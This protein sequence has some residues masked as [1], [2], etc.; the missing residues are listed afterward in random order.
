M[1][2]THF[3]GGTNVHRRALA[4]SFKSTE[5]LDGSSV[6]LVP[7][8]LGGL[9]FFI[10]HESCVSS[11]ATVQKNRGYFIGKAVARKYAMALP[12]GPDSQRKFMLELGLEGFCLLHPVP[13]RYFGGTRRSVFPANRERFICLGR[14]LLCACSGGK[15][16]GRW[17]F[18]CE[19]ESVLEDSGTIKF[20]RK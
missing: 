3:A 11:I 7:R 17:Q 12:I 6:V 2:Q 9:F 20:Y 13:F 4:D 15:R 16:A 14:S 5:N 8:A 18:F 10:T 1:V 19:L